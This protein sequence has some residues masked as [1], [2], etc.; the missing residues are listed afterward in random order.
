MFG[1]VIQVGGT[2][3]H[4][5][6]LPKSLPI[7]G[8]L[9]CLDWHRINL[10]G[11][12]CVKSSWRWSLCKIIFQNQSSQLDMSA[13]NY[14]TADSTRRAAPRRSCSRSAGKVARWRQ[15]S[16]SRWG[17]Y[18]LYVCLIAIGAGVVSFEFHLFD[19]FSFASFCTLLFFLMKIGLTTPE[20]SKPPTGGHPLCQYCTWTL[21]P[22]LRL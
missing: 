15:E 22:I 11:A 20:F 13:I 9:K 12:K 3:P 8:C 18:P 6:P 17:P 10:S 14:Y 21:R 1:F 16:T 4:H 19:C 2:H 5:H 7:S